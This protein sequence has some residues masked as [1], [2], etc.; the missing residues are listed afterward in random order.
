M[1]EPRKKARGTLFLVLLSLIVASSFIILFF[2]QMTAIKGWEHENPFP[3]AHDLQTLQCD[4]MNGDGILD[5]V[6]IAEPTETTDEGQI[7]NPYFGMVT[8][9]DGA[10][11]AVIWDKIL[12]GPAK[13][14]H[15]VFDLDGDGL[16]DF[17]LT[18]G[19][20]S[21]NW[22]TNNRSE[23]IPHMF[24][25]SFLS[26]RN[27]TIIPINGEVNLTN[28]Y[29]TDILVSDTNFSDEIE[30]FIIVTSNVTDHPAHSNI[31]AYLVNGS[32][33]RQYQYTKNKVSS[34]SFLNYSSDRFI[35]GFSENWVFLLNS[36]N[37]VTYTLSWNTTP[38]INV[39][40]EYFILEDL[41]GDNVSEVLIATHSRLYLLNATRG[42]IIDSFNNSIE[43]LSF[44]KLER[45]DDIAGDS[46]DDFL[47][48]FDRYP[49]ESYLLRTFS[50]NS[51]HLNFLENSSFDYP[52]LNV[53]FV[54]RRYTLDNQS[55]LF[56]IYE[57]TTTQEMDEFVELVMFDSFSTIWKTQG[58]YHDEYVGLI[59]N[60][61]ADW[62]GLLT[63]AGDNVAVVSAKGPS[64]YWLLFHLYPEYIHY[65]IAVITALVLLVIS[66]LILLLKRKQIHLKKTEEVSSFE[67]TDT[68]PSRTPLFITLFILFLITFL[69]IIVMTMAG[70]FNTT[71]ILGSVNE[72]AILGM[73]LA[74]LIWFTAFPLIP[75][76][77]KKA[78]AY[79]SIW[80]LKFRRF[81]FKFYRN[82]EKDIL[83]LGMENP[84]KL[85]LFQMFRRAIF[86]TLV[87][88]AIGINLYTYLAPSLPSI[89]VES[90]EF[91][92]FLYYFLYYAVIPMI[93]SYIFMVFFIP[94][95][96][97][98][99]DCGLVYYLSYK[100]D[101]LPADVERISSWALNPIKAI[102]GFTAIWSYYNLILTID[103]T[104]VQ[105]GPGSEMAILGQFFLYVFFYGFP[106][107]S[108][109]GLMMISIF[110]TERHLDDNRRN[111]YERMRKNGFKISS[112][113]I[114]FQDQGTPVQMKEE[115]KSDKGF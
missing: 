112:K 88:I 6:T 29:V 26:G 60:F 7:L 103:L 101:H 32:I 64:S 42:V 36:S 61:D 11:G 17:F 28:E 109:I 18:Y 81:T 5:L 97:L 44:R 108:G 55:K 30:D 69:F 107:I 87:S 14:I 47:V 10:T 13:K 59:P 115:H 50:V 63:A 95:S 100:Q 49:I 8:L 24:G 85:S 113:K 62:V 12:G 67:E 43:S 19:T 99:D 46:R 102:A 78:A 1:K 82:V 89:A 38:D 66:I 58:Y 105:T 52:Q 90:A 39:V 16:K 71:L 111:V 84:K 91:L 73:A 40:E 51:T 83:V 4:D 68:K 53:K 15:Q 41:D 76:L 65:F 9:H 98:I 74:F 77:Y 48:L 110:Y 22:T 79:Y 45:I 35:V 114:V 86:P 34:I 33:V 75:A 20:A 106:F 2:T 37:S 70:V 104:N 57:L 23:L 27:G 25:N 80:F 96:W 21:G 54:P 3:F 92:E 31:T 72:R 94:S 56:L 93:I